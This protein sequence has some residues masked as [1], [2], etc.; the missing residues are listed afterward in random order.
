M[1]A[2][3][4]FGYGSLVSPESMGRTIGRVPERGTDLLSA[5]LTG[6]GRRWNYGIGSMRGRWTG[7]DG[8]VVGDGTIVALGLVVASTEVV[9]GVVARIDERQLAALDRRERNY[10]RVEVA[11]G[12]TVLATP[13]CAWSPGDTVVT[14]VPRPGAVAAYE[15][16]RDAGTAAIRR[17]YWE[18]VA[19]AFAALGPEALE[20]Y[21]GT[22][23]EPDIPVA[24]VDVVE[25]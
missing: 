18:L 23:P 2:T 25:R 9:N 16:A 15:R 24:D 8:R 10:D 4:V 21:R 7:P 11:A 19:E 1:A 12:V 22:T 17:D 5:E 3:W 6:Y 14:Y 20:R 13:G